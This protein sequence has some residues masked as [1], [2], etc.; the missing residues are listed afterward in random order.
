MTARDLKRL[1]SRAFAVVARFLTRCDNPLVHLNERM[2]RTSEALTRIEQ[3]IDYAVA[4]I[5]FVRKHMANYLGNGVALTFLPDETPIYVNSNDFGP[6]SN[7]INGGTYEAD[8]LAVLLSFIRDDT[9][10]LDIGANLGFFSLNIARRVHGNGKVHAFEPHPEL[11]RLLR[12]SAFLNGFSSMDG[13]NG[14][15]ISHVI[16]VSDSNRR[17]DLYYPESHLGG[18]GVFERSEIGR[19][20]ISADFHTIDD[21]F[22]DDFTCDLVKIDVEGHELNVLMGMQKTI[23]RSPTVKIVFEKLSPNIGSEEAIERLLRSLGLD[24]YGIQP[25]ARLQK[26]PP[27]ALSDFAGY[28]LASLADADLENG[29]SRT[30]FCIFPRHFFTIAET[31]VEC[32]TQVLH[33]RGKE[34]DLLFHGPYWFL[35]RGVYRISFIGSIVGKLELTVAARFG[36]AIQVFDFSSSVLEG[37]FECERELVNFEVIGRAVGPSTIV[38]LNAI[39][40]ER[41]G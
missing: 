21:Y 22:G 24:L 4:G 8:N 38:E 12:G 11:A 19:S 7:F 27:K 14:A 35:G 39:R 32:R 13:T 3:K 25:G 15:L 26:L 41:V 37:Y 40:V 23:K 31:L 29:I 36:F 6:P 9:V 30:H 5:D 1:P 20:K 10:F 17:G 18:G 16:A 2:N 34:K 28:V 33:S